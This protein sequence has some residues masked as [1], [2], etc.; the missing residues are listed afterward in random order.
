MNVAILIEAI[1]INPD[2]KIVFI[3]TYRNRSRCLA[4]SVS[5]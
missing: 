2:E 4:F 3:L 5:S 1:I